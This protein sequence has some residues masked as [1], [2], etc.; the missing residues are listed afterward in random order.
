VATKKFEATQR[1][2][3]T[4][5]SWPSRGYNIYRGEKE[6]ITINIL[7]YPNPRTVDLAGIFL[8]KQ[9]LKEH[10]GAGQHRRLS[11][12]PEDRNRELLPGFAGQS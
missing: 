11:V 2:S 4:T 9:G 6:T 1:L 7:E 8:I 12:A 3:N 10:S 5:S